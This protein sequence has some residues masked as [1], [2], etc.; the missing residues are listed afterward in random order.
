MTRANKM[1]CHFNLF[2]FTYF[3]LVPLANSRAD[4]SFCCMSVR[5][6]P[7]RIAFCK[8]T[9]A[10]PFTFKRNPDTM[11]PKKNRLPRGGAREEAQG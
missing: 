9:G 6:I 2:V 8:D 5:I 10:G 11:T 1:P 3:P 7:D 4:I